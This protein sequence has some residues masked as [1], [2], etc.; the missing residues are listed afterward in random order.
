MLETIFK[1]VKEPDIHSSN[2]PGSQHINY[3]SLAGS[4]SISTFLQ[5][6]ANPA[7]LFNLLHTLMEN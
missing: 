7:F 3:K 5:T 2:M 4:C 6:A 1:I